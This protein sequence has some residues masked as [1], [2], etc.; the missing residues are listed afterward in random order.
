VI[1]VTYYYSAC[2]RI[3]SQDLS[4]LCDPW[5][6]QGAYDG[7]WYQF[8]PQPDALARIPACDFVYVSHIHPDHYDPVFLRAYLQAHPRARVIIAARDKNHL[9]EKMQRDRI[10]HRAIAQLTRGETLVAIVENAGTSYDVDSALVVKRGAHSVVN[11]NDNLL[12]ADH[13]A[14]IRELL[15]GRPSIALLGYTG[16][17]PYPQTYYSDPQVLGEKAAGKKQAFFLRYLA[18]RDALDPRLTIPFAG[19]YVLGGSLHALNPYRGVADACEILAID[20]R[21]VVLADGGYG[22]IDTETFEP[23]ATRTV[24]YDLAAVNAYAATLADRPMLYERYFGAVPQ[25]AL[26]LARLLPKAAANARS[27]SPVERDYYFCV[28]LSDRWFVCN[29]NRGG[30]DPGFCSE[31]ESFSP[32]SEITVAPRYL[33][34]L[35]TGCFHWNNAEIGSQYRTTRVPDEHDRDVQAFLN[36]FHV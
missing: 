12:S 8:P 17:G 3:E 5:F 29:A 32:R 31:V 25:S 24:P 21:A 2:V 35:L 11:M 6:T 19:K 9:S 26:P 27:R 22:S 1:R 28:R 10:E 16:A 23:T 18:M 20:P 34:G 7:S 36:F 4:I 30:T 14:R 15:S 13:V 33:F